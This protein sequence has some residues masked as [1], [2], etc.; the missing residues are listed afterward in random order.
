MYR[1]SDWSCSTQVESVI[2]KRHSPPLIIDKVQYAPALLRRIKADIEQHRDGTGRFLITGSQDFSLLEGVTESLAGRSAVLTLH[3][4]SAR[5]YEAW[6]GWTLD[7]EVLV[8]WMLHGGYPEL[9]RRGFDAERFFSDDLA[10]Y[11]ERHVRRR[12][13]RL[14]RAC[15]HLLRERHARGRQPG[16]QGRV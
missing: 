14:P 13:G 6:S 1:P 3:S 2:I 10:T 4:L 5:E 9:H 16:D 11:L 15:R 8:E 12:E 7:T